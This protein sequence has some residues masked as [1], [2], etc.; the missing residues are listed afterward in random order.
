M[1]CRNDYILLD[2]YNASYFA[3]FYLA[4]TICAMSL[5]DLRCALPRN[6][7]TL[8]IA[9]QRRT[10]HRVRLRSRSYGFMSY[11]SRTKCF[12]TRYILVLP[13]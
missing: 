9:F 10:V 8:L 13:Y 12:Q 7:V 2:A 1:I 6:I 4:L 3:M 11:Y 5:N